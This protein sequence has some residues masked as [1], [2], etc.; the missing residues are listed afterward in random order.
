MRPMVSG[1]IGIGRVEELEPGRRRVVAAVGILVH[2]APSQ[3]HADCG[4]ST[5]SWLAAEQRRVAPVFAGRRELLQFLA[6]LRTALHVVRQLGL[7]AL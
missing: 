7:L 5:R 1:S 4:R 3:T 6:A 2:R